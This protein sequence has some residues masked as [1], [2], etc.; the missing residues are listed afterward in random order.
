MENFLDNLVKTNDR[1]KGFTL[2]SKPIPFKHTPLFSD[3]YVCIQI[4]DITPI[5]DHDIVGFSG[6]CKVKGNKIVP[7]DRDS[8]SP[9]MVVVG[10]SEFMNG[11]SLCLDLLVE[12]W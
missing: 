11:D 10:Y 2:Y 5:G 4:H 6:V 1:Y 8:Y 7:L 3:K 9:N 12:N